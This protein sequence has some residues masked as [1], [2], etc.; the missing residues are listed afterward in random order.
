MEVNVLVLDVPGRLTK[1]RNYFVTFLKW[2]LLFQPGEELFP[3]DENGKIIYDSVDL[4]RTWEVSPG[5]RK[6]GEESGEGEPPSFL[7]PVIM[8]C[9]PSESAVHESKDWDAGVVGRKP[10]LKCSQ[11]RTESGTV[12]PGICFFP[13]DRSSPGFSKEEMV[14]SSS[15]I[16]TFFSFFLS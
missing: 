15:C 4:C 10:L 2:L 16:M 3:K 5:R 7:P 13:C 11:K 1:W 8:G 14:N 9:G 12:K 6:P